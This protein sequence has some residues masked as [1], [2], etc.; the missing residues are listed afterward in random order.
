MSFLAVCHK[1]LQVTTLDYR[2]P[3]K[4]T[5]L[6]YYSCLTLQSN[7]TFCMRSEFSFFQSCSCLLHW[8]RLTVKVKIY[9]TKILK[10]AVTWDQTSLKFPGICTIWAFSWIINDGCSTILIRFI[11]LF[12]LPMVATKG[13]ITLMWLH[14]TMK[15]PLG[16][17]EREEMK[18]LI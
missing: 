3:L 17:G 18:K 5:W 12:T 1:P 14:T 15:K 4:V 7:I 13:H 8:D 16:F 2:M 11:D 9:Q 10:Q 6:L